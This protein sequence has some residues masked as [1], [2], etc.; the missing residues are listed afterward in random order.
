MAGIAGGLYTPRAMLRNLAIGTL[1]FCA[2]SAAQSTEEVRF[3]HALTGPQAAEIERL[4]AR[5]NESQT[6]YR[7]LPSYKGSLEVTFARA[8]A[9]KRTAAAPHIVQIHSSL[10]HDLSTH[11][12]LV[13]LSQVMANAN[14]PFDAA[15]FPPLASAFSHPHARP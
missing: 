5:F 12:L 11:Q 4:A 3:W 7:V 13:P 6:D 2:A 14:Q 15:L 1:F 10:T 8:L 9:A